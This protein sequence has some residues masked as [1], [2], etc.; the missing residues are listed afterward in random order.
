MNGIS[1]LT[2]EYLALLRSGESVSPE[3]FASNHPEHEKELLELLPGLAAMEKF[4]KTQKSADHPIRSL[5]FPETLGEYRLLS[6]IGEGGMGTVFK[7]IQQ[8]LNREVA[9]KILSPAWSNNETLRIRFE[10]ESKVI[11]RLHHPNI[12]QV[13]GAGHESDYSFYVMELVDGTGLD[14]TVPRSATETAKI[15]LQAADALA[16]AHSC[17][18]LHRDV[19][20]ANLLLDVNQVLR[21]SDFGIATVLN[22]NSGSVA[23]T[24]SRDGTLRY[25]APER[26]LRNEDTFASDQYSLGLTLY[27]LLSGAPAFAET[28]PGALVKS[29][30]SH[31]IVPLKN[32]DRDLSVIIEKSIA[33]SPADRYRGMAEMADDLRR[34]LAHEPVKARRNG[35]W[36]RLVLWR[37]RRPAVAA[38]SAAAFILTLSLILSLVV[39]YVRTNRVLRIADETLSEIFGTYSDQPGSK[40]TELLLKLLPYYES[41]ASRRSGYANSVIGKIAMRSNRP[42][43]AER[44]FRKTSD[45]YSLALSLQM[46]GKT[47]QAAAIWRELAG[48]NGLEALK[49]NLALAGDIRPLPGK[50]NADGGNREALQKAFDIAVPLLKKQPDNPE[51]RFLLASIL[52]ADPKLSRDY[53]AMELLRKLVAEY[54]DIVSYRLLFLRLAG[55]VHSSKAN[56]DDQ[57]KV[58]LEQADLLLSR[59]PNEPEVIATACDV[60]LKYAL[61]LAQRKQTANA[62]RELDESIG[63]LKIIA[64]H[65]DAPAAGLEKL[66]EFQFRLTGILLRE[67]RLPEVRTLLAELE[68]EINGYSG[69]SKTAFAEELEKQKRKLEKI[70]QHP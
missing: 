1:K 65:D 7:A 55:K 50:E 6:K 46:Q 11:A 44:A 18:I 36:K 17:R 23:A 54:P 61:A 51:I 3:A 4:G 45:R 27:E 26:L 8:S 70:L 60:K 68:T 30:C 22:E 43:I 53:D 28:N 69:K 19:K 25:M 62:I 39:G 24:Q 40:N 57:I 59:H 37:K 2:E 15:G 20:P 33:F 64:R 42:D 14:I 31:D 10:N 32:G 63:L 47:G 49:A 38:L 16:Y 66:I 29:I 41:I 13:F 35:L 52:A 12:V 58:A 67:S 34:Y 9:V 56:F 5:P 21:V 48:G